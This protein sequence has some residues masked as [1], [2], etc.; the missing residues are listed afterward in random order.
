MPIC[1]NYRK[2]RTVDYLISLGNFIKVPIVTNQS[3]FIKLRN[4][5]SRFIM[6][7][8]TGIFWFLRVC[9]TGRFVKLNNICETTWQ[10]IIIRIT[11]KSL[12]ARIRAYGHLWAYERTVVQIYP[13][14]GK[15]PEYEY[16]KLP[17]HHFYKNLK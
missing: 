9:N 12:R 11:F 2:L 1:R 17:V 16:Q 14:S 4:L 8:G 3:Y 5:S 13:N 10:R 6:I 7:T 15:L